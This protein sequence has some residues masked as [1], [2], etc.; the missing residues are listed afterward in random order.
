MRTTGCP[1]TTEDK[2]SEVHL[3]NNSLQKH[4][5]SYSRYE[6]GNTLPLTALDDEATGG[7]LQGADSSILLPRMKD[8]VIDTYLA[9]YSMARFPQKKI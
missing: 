4:L 2:S 5:D 3:T 9:A 7:R 8:L 1:Y 6:E